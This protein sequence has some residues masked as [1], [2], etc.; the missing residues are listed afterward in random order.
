MISLG[1]FKDKRAVGALEVCKLGLCNDTL[2]VMIKGLELNL[3][4]ELCVDLTVV[5]MGGRKGLDLSFHLMESLVVFF[6][7]LFII[8]K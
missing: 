8:I 5:S 2:P 7:D 4:S 1:V 6:I 3:G